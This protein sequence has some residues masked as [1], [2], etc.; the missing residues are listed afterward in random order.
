MFGNQC[1]FMEGLENVIKSCGS[2]FLFA[3]ESSYPNPHK[4]IDFQSMR[5]D[6]SGNICVKFFHSTQATSQS[7]AEKVVILVC[8][9]IGLY[10]E[11]SCLTLVSFILI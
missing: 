7:L 4:A 9:V 1:Q 8:S 6:I 2:C 11:L 3:I 5:D 10:D